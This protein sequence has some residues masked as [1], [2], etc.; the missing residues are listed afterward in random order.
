MSAVFFV[1]TFVIGIAF[2]VS[3]LFGSALAGKYF[4]CFDNGS[5][6]PGFLVLRIQVGSF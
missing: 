4:V 5:D 6:C 2:L 3:L 1:G